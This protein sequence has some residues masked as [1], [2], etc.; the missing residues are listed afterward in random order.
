MIDAVLLFVSE[1]PVEKEKSLLSGGER[2]ATKGSDNIL[3]VITSGHS[4]RFEIWL[5]RVCSLNAEV[6]LVQGKD[7]A[8]GRC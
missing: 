5:D 2:P 1:P 8:H 3:T 4:S 7:N 6:E